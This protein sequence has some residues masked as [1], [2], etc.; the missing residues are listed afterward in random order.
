MVTKS[1]PV[2][3]RP[4]V[5]GDPGMDQGVVGALCVAGWLVLS[6]GLL[7][8]FDRLTVIMY[9]SVVLLGLFVMAEYMSLRFA[10]DPLK[11]RNNRLAGLGT[12]LYFV[13]AEYR[14]AIFI[15]DGGTQS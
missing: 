13:Y 15:S 4:R 9:L 2:R 8:V 1:K 3:S 10:S 5:A 6:G 12:I 11:T 7:A 14:V